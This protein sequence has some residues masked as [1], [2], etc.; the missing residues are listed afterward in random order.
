MCQYELV[1]LAKAVGDFTAIEVDVQFAF[2]HIDASNNT[3]V[4]VVERCCCSRHRDSVAMHAARHIARLQ[5][6]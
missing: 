1:E 6:A 5:A 4:A 3:K 2:L